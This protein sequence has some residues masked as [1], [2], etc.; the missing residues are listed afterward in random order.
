MSQAIS[1]ALS[2]DFQDLI[3]F[4]LPEDG[5]ASLKEP[6]AERLV[7]TFQASPRPKR[8]AFRV[9]HVGG[10][11]PELQ[12]EPAEPEPPVERVFA[13][14]SLAPKL[15]KQFRNQV[16]SAIRDFS[17]IQPG[18]KVLVGLS[19][20]KDSLTLLHALLHMK[21]S[22]PVKFEVGAATV[23]PQTPEYRPQ[24]LIAYMEALKV[25][26]HFLSKPIIEMAREHMDP[27]RP[28]LCAFCARMK[29][30]LLYTCMREHGYNVLALGQH[31]DD[32]AESFLMSTFRN[33]SLRTMKAS[34]MVEQEDLR[35]IRPL[36][37]VR[38]KVMDRLAKE[39]AFPVI[40]DNCPACFAQPKERHRMKMLLSQ[41]E[42]E[43][44][45]LFPS[46]MKALQPL[47]AISS[48]NKQDDWYRKP[49]KGDTRKRPGDGEPE[50]RAPEKRRAEEHEETV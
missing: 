36:V 30:G 37:Y 9:G 26:F 46:I 28:S 13:P 4:A 7:E 32:V 45:Q 20:G 19:G 29:R 38:E 18:D 1:P 34:Y 49:E 12:P 23:D 16:G 8:S 27:K 24:P 44:P 31:L 17:M 25:P 40:T 15:P 10:V 14:R 3:W 33:G 43:F 41:Q 42:G 22:A 35:V 2:P 47:L 50:D 6:Q 48:A 21:R 39:N 11:A 5:A